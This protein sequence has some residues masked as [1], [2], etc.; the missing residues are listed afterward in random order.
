MPEHIE[1]LIQSDPL[2]DFV[3]LCDQLNTHKSESLVRFIA[4]TLGDVQVL[5][6]GSNTFSA[7]TNKY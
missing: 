3:I 1:R 7:Q 2:A 4:Q 5:E 6:S